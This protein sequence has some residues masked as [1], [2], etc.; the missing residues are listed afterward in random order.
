MKAVAAADAWRGSLRWV[1]DA[2][3]EVPHGFIMLALEQEDCQAVPHFPDSSRCHDLLDNRTV[4]REDDE[5][6]ALVPITS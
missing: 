2:C 1:N 5:V 4:A 3:E 6:L